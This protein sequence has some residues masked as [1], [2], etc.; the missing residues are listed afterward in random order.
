VKPPTQWDAVPV[1]EVKK[2]TGHLKRLF[3]FL[4]VDAQRPGKLQREGRRECREGAYRLADF[5]GPIRSTF[6]KYFSGSRDE[7]LE[8]VGGFIDKICHASANLW[9][10]VACSDFPSIPFLVLRILPPRRCGKGVGMSP[11]QQPM[12]RRHKNE[13]NAGSGGEH[14]PPLTIFSEHEMRGIQSIAG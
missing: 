3:L 4:L 6:S 1:G 8:S 11:R 9:P 5:T 2:A 14:Q 10:L 12:S 13:G 7:A